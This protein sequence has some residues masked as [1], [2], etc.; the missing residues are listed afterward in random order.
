MDVTGGTSIDLHDA[1]LERIEVL[2]QAKRCRCFVRTHHEGASRV[3]CL[4]FSE[5]ADISMPHVEPWGPS[6]SILEHTESANDYAIT[7][8]SGDVIRI[9]AKAWCIVND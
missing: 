7:M 4:E 6:S 9:R 1:I 2:W 8:Q 5:V 3:I